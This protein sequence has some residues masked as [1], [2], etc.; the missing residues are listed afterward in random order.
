MPI[1]N[2][3]RYGAGFR[4][5][6]KIRKIESAAAGGHGVVADLFDVDDDACIGPASSAG[7]MNETATTTTPR[8]MTEPPRNV[9][10]FQPPSPM[11]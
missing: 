10:G 8:I 4:Y 6:R 2:D 7:T 5:E 1:R 3:R 11:A 9:N